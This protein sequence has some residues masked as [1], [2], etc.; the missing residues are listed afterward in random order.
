MVYLPDQ[1]RYTGMEY[2]RSGHSG[3]KLPL[4]SLGLWHNFGGVDQFENARKMLFTAFDQGITHFDLANNYGPPP[5]SAEQT[6]GQIMRDS[7]KPFRDEMIISTKAGYLIWPGPY[8]EWG[9]RKYL[10]ASLDQSLARMNLDDVDIC[11]AHRLDPE[12]PLEETM[13]ALA[14]A[15]A[16]GKALYAGISNYPPDATREAC[17]LLREMNT[18]CLIHQVK[19]SMFQPGAAGDLAQVLTHEGVGCIAFSPLAQGMLSNR[20]LHG[21]PENSRAGKPHGFLKA[22]EL[23]DARLLTIKK[24]NDYATL[25]GISLAELALVWVKSHPFITS[26]LIGASSTEQLLTN[27]RM[28]NHPSLTE[29]EHS[30][31]LSILVSE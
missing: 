5:G 9:S 3:L 27:I 1:Q 28:V 20:Y 23:S 11:Y 25:K 12:T 16:S 29:S 15:V 31:I 21:I 22:E 4:L 26:V 13:G 10:L 6:F 7:F 8:G 24:L 19:F 14:S 30:E 17:R 18:P 2:R